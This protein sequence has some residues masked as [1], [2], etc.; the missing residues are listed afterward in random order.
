MRR[1]GWVVVGLLLATTLA[2]ADDDEA[3]K[4]RCGAGYEGGQRQRSDG[5]LLAA[6]DAFRTCSRDCS[7]SLAKQCVEWLDEVERE[8]PTIVLSVEGDDRTDVRV[9]LDGAPLRESLDGRPVEVDPGPH[10]VRF[11]SA[12]GKTS[13]EK[14]VVIRSAERLQAVSLPLA[15]VPV[16][17]R[18]MSKDLRTG[19][20]VRRPFP[21]YS[22]VAAGFFVAS[23][24]VG[25]GLWISGRVM[26][27]SLAKEGCAPFCDP[28]RVD[29][30]DAR[31]QIG[32]IALGVAAVSLAVTLITYV[33]RPTRYEQ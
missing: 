11:A 16:D 25:T 27:S 23:A 10:V 31:Y 13:S 6:R 26:E 17:P 1:A 3:R 12:D 4:A 15:S 22:G 30:I 5:K 21:W 20:G 14:K 18:W 28:A 2:H 8:I 33:L 9:T 32:A 7:P 19:G 29:P 24:A